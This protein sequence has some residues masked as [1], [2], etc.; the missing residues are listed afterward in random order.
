MAQATD[1]RVPLGRFAQRVF[2]FVGILL[3]TALVAYFLWTVGRGFLVIFAGMLFAV[4]LD[5]LARLIGRFTP[6]GHRIALTTALVIVA[7]LVFGGGWLGGSHL[8][9]QA[10]QLS[11]RISHSLN[12]IHNRLIEKT[13]LSSDKSGS[14]SHGKSGT[15]EVLSYGKRMVGNVTSLLSITTSAITDA[16][17]I[18]ILGIY[19]ALAPRY[20]LEITAL[21]IPPARRGHVVNALN[22]IGHALRRWFLGRIMAMVLVGVLTTI[23]LYALG[24]ELSFLLGIIAGLFTFVPYLGAIISAVP[25][26]LVGLSNGPLIAQIGRAHV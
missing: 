25:A 22:T 8:A 3:P 18:A 15:S 19:F 1:I 13:S 16:F 10:P 11:K 7:L 2:I 6:F 20:Y 4:L 5:G 26:I 17:I 12:H 9:M 23:G 21:L 24:V 14:Q